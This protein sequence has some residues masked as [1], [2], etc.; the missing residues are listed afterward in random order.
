MQPT[1]SDPTSDQ[2]YDI[3]R[4]S[5]PEFNITKFLDNAGFECEEMF[6]VCS[7]AGRR[8]NCCNYTSPFMTTFGK[9]YALDLGRSKRPWM[10]KQTAAGADAGLQII[11]DAQ[12]DEQLTQ[13][14]ATAAAY[15][16]G[17][18]YYVHANNTLAYLNSEGISVS[19]GFRSYSAISS[20]RYILLPEEEWGNCTHNWPKNYTTSLPYSFANCAHFCKARYFN[21]LCGCAPAVYNIDHQFETCTPKATSDCISMKIKNADTAEMEMPLCRECK[22]ECNSLVFHAFNS[23]GQGFTT[24]ALRYLRSNENTKWNSTYARQNGVT[25][26]VFF[27]DM[28][29]TEYR[30]VQGTSITQILSDMGGNMGLFLG[31]SVF[32]IAE[33]SLFLTKISWLIVS[34]KRR[35]YM[36]KKK[37]NEETREKELEEAVKDYKF[38]RTRKTNNSF[39]VLRQKVKNLASTIYKQESRNLSKKKKVEDSKE[40]PRLAR[41]LTI[42]APDMNYFYRDIDSPNV[43]RR[44]SCSIVELSVDEKEL[45]AG[46]DSLEA[47][48]KSNKMPEKKLDHTIIDM[49]DK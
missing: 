46:L 18:R 31:M 14:S 49:G 26:N 38:F 29:H 24:S 9:C 39:R 42:G 15:E 30:Q 19:P 17:F 8:F 6:R 1:I 16:N 34:K 35:D 36:Y 4:E 41:S 10:Q 12:S 32:S 13:G 23:Y 47:W 11:L 20:N 45:R 3:Y 7:F 27:R 25:I 44:F 43:H 37:K 48:E 28:S 21:E 5:H 22:P 2:Q 33:L 40:S